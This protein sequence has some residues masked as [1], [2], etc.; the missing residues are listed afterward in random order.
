MR[1]VP[2]KARAFVRRRVES[3][4]DRKGILRS[5]D[6]H[7]RQ[8]LNEAVTAA[9]T[10]DDFLKAQPEETFKKMGAAHKAL[11][12]ALNN[13]EISWPQAMAK[14][15]EFAAEAQQLAQITQDLAALTQ[16]K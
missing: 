7:A 3:L 12:A 4:V 6:A 16:K 10:Y 15:Q 8:K 13:S 14:I 1:I 5:I 2:S 9:K 11:A